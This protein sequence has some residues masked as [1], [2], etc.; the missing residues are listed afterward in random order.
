MSA[1]VVGDVTINRVLS[2]LFFETQSSN[3]LTYGAVE[4]ALRGVGH[5][6]SHILKLQILG[7][8]MFALNVRAVRER[9]GDADESGMVP[10]TYQFQLMTPT[11]PIVPLKS[12]RCWHYQCAEGAVPEDPLYQVF[13]TISNLMAMGIVQSLPA[14]DAAPWG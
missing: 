11:G 7:E 1:F 13:E 5:E 2:W 4:R 10:R 12:L 6:A 3:G 14:Y 9:Y 8:A